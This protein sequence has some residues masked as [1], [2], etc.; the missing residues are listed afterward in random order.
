MKRYPLRLIPETKAAIW[1]GSRLKEQYGIASELPRVAEAWVLSVR[2][3]AVNRI[4]EGDAAGMTL[5]DYFAAVGYDAVSPAWDGK[6]FPLLVK[7]IDAADELSV[8]V[9]PDDTYARKTANSPGKTEMWYIVDAEPG[10]TLIMGLA[11]GVDERGFADAVQAGEI[12]RTLRE[13]PVQPGDSFFIPSGM[14]HAIGRGI[15]IAEIQQNADLT[16]R[17]WD[18]DRRDADGNLRQL[19]IKQALDCVRPISDSEAN[20]LAYAKAPDNTDPSLLAASAYF[21]VQKLN[22]CGSAALE[23]PNDSFLSLLAV[24]G[25]GELTDADGNTYALAPGDSFFL[26]AGTGALTLSGELTVLLSRP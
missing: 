20:R 4:A 8:Q 9:H 14:L 22:V 19:H 6:E 17:V 12:K 10:A 16:Y 23:V 3:G 13:V 11:E 15:L 24:S 26:P 5:S 7:L 25:K 21:T 1:G 18:Y 2:N